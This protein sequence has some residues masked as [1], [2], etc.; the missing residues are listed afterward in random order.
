MLGGSVGLPALEQQEG[1]P[2]VRTAEP[3]VD[4]E[5][6]AVAADR[7]LQLPQAT[8]RDRHVLQH[9]LIVRAIAQRQ[10]VRRQRAS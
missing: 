10:P 2:V 1:E 9:L 6:A 3:G 4:L 8:V 5:C 7:V